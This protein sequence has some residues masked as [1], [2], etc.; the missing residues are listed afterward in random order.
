MIAWALVMILLVYTHFFGLP[1]VA[2]FVT[3]NFLY[4]RRPWAFTAAAAVVGL[5]YLPWLLYV[6]PIYIS[7]GLR[8]HISWVNVY[9]HRALVQLPFHFLG[10]IWYWP[11]QYLA[12]TAAAGLVH[13]VL[14]AFAWRGVRQL[15]PLGRDRGSTGRWLWSAALLAGI[16]VLL[17]YGFSVA[18][19]PAFSPRFVL[20]A[21]PG[22]WLLIVLLGQIG[23]RAARAM[24]YGVILPWTLVSVGLSIVGSWSPSPVR[25][26]TLFLAHEVRDTDVILCQGT[27]NRVYWEWTR[28]LGRSGRIEVLRFGPGIWRLSVLRPKE[29]ESID[30]SRADRVWL[31]YSSDQAAT[32]VSEFLAGQGY[33]PI[34]S[35]SKAVPSLL[36]FEKEASGSDE[37]AAA[38][39]EL[40]SGVLLSLRPGLRFQTFEA[41]RATA[42]GPYFLAGGANR[43]VPPAVLNEI[44]DDLAFDLGLNGLRLEVHEVQALEAIND[45]DDP[46]MFNWSGFEFARSFMLGRELWD[47][48]ARIQQVVLPLKQRVESRGE[49]FSSYVSPIYDY[50]EFPRHWHDPEEYA[51]FAEAYL[52]WLRD[53]FGFTPTYWAVVN[54]PSPR[55]FWPRNKMAA[56]IATVGRRLQAKGFSTK[57]Q[58]PEAVAPRKAVWMLDTIINDPEVT[59]Y[60][61]MISYHGYDYW[62]PMPSRYHMEHRYSISTRGTQLGVPT[63]MTEI[64]CRRGWNQGTYEH[65]F[66]L[67]RDIYWN[68]TEANVSVWEPLGSVLACAKS[69]CSPPGG[70]GDLLYLAPDL[71]TYYKLP[72]YYAMRQ[73]MHYIRPGYVRVN[74]TCHGCTFDPTTGQNVK[75]VVFRS[76]QGKYVVV[77]INDQI[78]PQM[79]RLGGFPAGTY[80]ITGVD[81]SHTGSRTYLD[82]T[83]SSG[84]VL[85][86]ELPGRAIATVVQDRAILAVKQ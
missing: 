65:G 84:Q 57:I 53:S 74:M 38:S 51:E 22:Y 62:K 1:L 46:F 42:S 23:G 10:S 78:D 30:L 9:P 40:F 5:A 55:F 83:I 50:G 67:A 68:L 59:Q 85:T 44:L 75:P 13:L 76:P 8:A 37:T 11:A 7:D 49:P 43:L 69:G 35:L 3:V 45:N 34:R 60:I 56:A 71:S 63:A 81:P 48:A 77:V 27:C 70:G 29:L 14:L 39:N 64:C 24:L 52:T 15:W 66:E 86:L 82:E 6:L 54:E 47:P 16:P 20:G 4:G 41:W 25:Q 21:L 26:G 58:F 72:N 31:F 2:A 17:L 28:R 79:V 80:H 19:T 73:F 12:L 36:A 32:W 61:G 18:V 33:R